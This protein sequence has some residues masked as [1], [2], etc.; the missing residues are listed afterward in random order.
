MGEKSKK[1]NLIVKIC[2]IIASFALWLYVYNVENPIKESN[3]I[4]PVKIINQTNAKGLDLAMVQEEESTVSIT[5]RGNASDIYSV[6]PEQFNLEADLSSYSLKKGLNKIPVQV[7]KSPKNIKIVN[8][9]NLWTKVILDKLK[10]KN[11]KVNIKLMGKTKEGYFPVTPKANLKTALVSGTESSVN[12]VKDVVAVCNISESS[13]YIN[14]KV[15]LKARDS[16]GNIVKNVDIEP[17]FAQVEVPIERVKS[18]KVKL[19]LNGDLNNN[20]YIESI[21]PTVSEVKI[22]GKD[23]IINNIEF[24]ST[25][26][27]DINNI[28]TEKEY[29]KAKL[30]LPKGVILVDKNDSVNLKIT[31]RKN[32]NAEKNNQNNKPNGSVEGNIITRNFVKDIDILN[33]PNDKDVLLSKT[34]VEI[35]VKGNGSDINNLNSNDIKCFVDLKNIN[36]GE[37]NL[38]VVVQLPDNIYKVSSDPL[39]VHVTIKPKQEENN[40]VKNQ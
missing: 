4:V 5:I 30:M 6:K 27:I 10:S 18:V 24:L 14:K 36:E 19:N 2:C 7:K 26:I 21:I 35:V 3:I 31:F 17:S 33:S 39:D 9:D 12:I 1:E 23:S 13:N 22:T 32:K 15:L 25:E 29:I 8:E 20:K 37:S 34:S 40:A 38:P 16:N 28:K 11:V